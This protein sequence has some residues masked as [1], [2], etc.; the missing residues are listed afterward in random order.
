M[1]FVLKWGLVIGCLV[2]SEFKKLW[3]VVFYIILVGLLFFLFGP[4]LDLRSGPENYGSLSA[5]MYSQV[6]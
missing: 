2:S 6:F 3:Y 1:R 5:I 4:N